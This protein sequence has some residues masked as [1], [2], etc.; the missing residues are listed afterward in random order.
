MSDT[1]NNLRKIDPEERMRLLDALVE[2]TSDAIIGLDVDHNVVSWNAGAQIMLGYRAEEIVGRSASALVAP[3][4]RDK[5][6]E[7][8]EYLARG[9]TLSNYETQ[10]LRKDGQRVY[11]SL[12]SSHLKNE[13]GVPVGYVTVVR[14][15]TESN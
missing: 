6:Q 14:D 11:V 2:S 1:V 3:E 15:L 10:L 8:R 13:V 4:R 7:N 9:G 5:A 12:S